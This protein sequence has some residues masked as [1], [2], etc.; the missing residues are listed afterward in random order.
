MLF[1]P[2]DQYILHYSVSFIHHSVSTFFTIRSVHSSPFN[3]YFLHHSISTFFTIQS[4]LSSPFDQY[5]LHHSIS[6]FFTIQSVL[7]S[8]L[9]QYILHHSVSTFFT[10]QSVLSSPFN[11]HFF[12]YSVSTFSA[13]QSILSSSLKFTSVIVRCLYL[14]SSNSSFTFFLPSISVSQFFKFVFYFLQPWMY[15][16]KSSLAFVNLQSLLFSVTSFSNRADER[17][18]Y[19]QYSCL[20]TKYSKER[21]ERK[22]PPIKLGGG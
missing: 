10:I 5:I 11:Q 20:K 6:T 17:R 12:H 3:Q 21:S 13:L 14:R 4:V 2:L 22:Y 7:S 8:P 1:S 19:S 16:S 18:G 15:S 9:T